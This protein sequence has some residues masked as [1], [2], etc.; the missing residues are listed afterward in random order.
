MHAWKIKSH[1]PSLWSGNCQIRR[2]SCPCPHGLTSS[3]LLPTII[4]FLLLLLQQS[5]GWTHTDR[6]HS[7]LHGPS[8]LT[9]RTRQKPHGP[10]WK[11]KQSTAGPM[12]LSCRAQ[13]KMLGASRGTEALGS[14]PAETWTT[15]IGFRA[16]QEEKGWANFR[17]RAG[18]QDV[19]AL[20]SLQNPTPISAWSTG[21]E[22]TEAQGEVTFPRATHKAVC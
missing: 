2:G 17:L 22:E 14:S 11:A 16:S 10:P 3:L 15:G 20:R 5:R 1:V 13:V 4:P 18:T 9:G 6:R 12:S 8:L 7:R 21:T 19:R